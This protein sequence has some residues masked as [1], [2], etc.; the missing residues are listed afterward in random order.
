MFIPL[1]FIAIIAGIRLAPVSKS[2]KILFC[3]MA[4]TIFWILAV[5]SVSTYSS[6]RLTTDPKYIGEPSNY[7]YFYQHIKN[8]VIALVLGLIVYKIPLKMF[9]NRKYITWIFII[10]VLLQLA[11]FMP[12]IWKKLLGARGWINLWFTTIQPSEFFKI[13]YVLFMSSWMMRKK[14][15]L[16]DKNF[17]LAFIIIN[18]VILGVFAFIP[19]FWTVLILGSVSIVMVWYAG[20][21]KKNIAII[22]WT[23]L[24]SFLVLLG[25]LNLL[26]R[27]TE[28]QEVVSSGGQV[29]T[30]KIVKQNKFSY[31]KNRLMGYFNRGVDEEN[32]WINWQ[33]NQAK[34]AIWWWGFWGQG[35]WKGL[36]KFGYIPIAQSDFIFS[37]YSEEVGFLGDSMVLILY[38][39]MM[40]YF[41]SALKNTRDELTRLFWVGIISTIIL[42]MFINIWVNLGIVPNT[43]ITLP[44]ISH[45]W[46]AFMANVIQLTFLYTITRQHELWYQKR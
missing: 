5:Y 37:A 32:K 38:F 30:Q 19:D 34:L 13:A 22:L 7:Y 39:L 33:N 20:L 43:G 29:I 36:Q 11:V 31:L 35:Y 10:A 8:I 2:K 45:G 6:F 15:D 27:E 4:L 25:I 41:L 9:T 12:V 24:L 18:V 44:F 16:K 3:G 21:S 14:T 17:V 42:Q 46:T 1:L 28:T 23:A 40:Y 26:A